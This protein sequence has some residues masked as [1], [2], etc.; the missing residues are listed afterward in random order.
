MMIEFSRSQQVCLPLHM[1]H[2]LINCPQL[3]TTESSDSANN[4]YYHL[5]N[6]MQSKGLFHLCEPHLLPF[7]VFRTYPRMFCGDTSTI[8]RMSYKG[9][10]VYVQGLGILS[11]PIFYFFL[12][13]LYNFVDHIVY[14]FG[15]LYCDHKFDFPYILYKLNVAPDVALVGDYNNMDLT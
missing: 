12:S 10:R 15:V 6:S 4:T 7:Q 5:V 3:I 1:N 2:V 11:H 9:H 8:L 14:R 13:L